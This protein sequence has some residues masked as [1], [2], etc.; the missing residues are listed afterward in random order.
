MKFH[1]IQITEGSNVGNLTVASGTAF[2]SNANE[3]E[4]FYRS[5][6][7]TTVKGLYLY[8][9]GNWDRIASADSITAPSGVTFP[10]SAN[11]GDMFYKDSDDAGEGLYVYNGATW[12][13]AA[14][15]SGSTATATGDV[16]GVLTIGGSGALTLAN[17]GVT[18]GSF[19]GVTETLTLTVDSK[20]RVT[21]VNDVQIALPAAQV[22]SGTFD[23]ARVA[24]SNV[25]QHQAALALDGSQ[26]TSG[27]IPDARVA[28]SNVTQHQAALSILESQI[29]DGAIFPRINGSETITG[30]YQFNNPVVVPTP[31]SGSHATSKDYVDQAIAGL[32]WKNSVRV[33]TTANI[34]LSG[35]Q[36]IDGVLLSAGNRVLVKDQSTSSQNGVYVVAAGAW[37]RSTDFDSI[38]PIDE[39]NSAAVFVQQGTVNADTAWTQISPVSLVGTDAITF[40]QFAGANTYLAGAGMTLSTNTF[41][42]GTASASRIVVN[43]DNIDLATVGTPV[44]DVLRRVTTDAYGRVTGT[45]A[46][47]AADLTGVLDSTYVNV[48]GDTMT[49][50]LTISSGAAMP[51]TIESSTEFYMNLNSTNVKGG[52]QR[53]QT[54]GTTYL[55]IGTTLNTIGGAGNNNTPGINARDSRSL[56]LSTNQIE[57]MRIA[58]AGQVLIGTTTSRGN[59]FGAASGLDS[60]LQIEGTTFVT[61][62]ATYTRNSA[63]TNPSYLVLAKTR[64]GA[65]GGNT[66]VAAADALGIV[67]FQGADGTNVV[68]AA[69]IRGSADLTPSAGVVPG[70]L[71]FWTANASGTITERMRI[72]SNGNVAVNT[73]PNSWAKLS[74]AG[75]VS[76]N[77]AIGAVTQVGSGVFSYEAPVFREYIGD[78]TGYSRTFSKRTASTTTDLITILD[79]SGNFG[80][81]VTSPLSRLDVRNVDAFSTVVTDASLQNNTSTVARFS[82]TTDPVAAITG[83]TGVA[84]ALS[85][86]PNRGESFLVSTHPTASKDASEFAIWT[87]NGGVAAERLKVGVSSIS[88]GN[89][90]N[91][92]ISEGTESLMNIFRQASSGATVLANGMKYTGAANGFASSYSPTWAR[93]AI[94]LGTSNGAGSIGFYTDPTSVVAAGTDVS[95]T[96]RMLI[97]NSGNVGIGTVP[98]AWTNTARAIEFSY[99]TFGMD[100]PGQAFMAFN[101]RE[102]SSGNWVYKSTDTGQ[103]FRS[104]AGGWIWSTAASGTIGGAATVTERMRLDASGNLCVGRTS[105]SGLG[106]IQTDGNVDF[107]KTTGNQIVNVRASST[108][109]AEVSIASN[110]NSQGTSDFLL[111][112]SSTNEAYIWNRSSG[113]MY[114]GTANTERMRLSASGADLGLGGTP[115]SNGAGWGTLTVNGSSG[116]AVEFNQAGTRYGQ[117]L[118]N[119]AEVR[120]AATGSNPINFFTGG[121]NSRMVITTGG[122]IGMGGNSTGVA[123]GLSH[124]AVIQYAGGGSVYGLALRSMANTTTAVSFVNAADATVGNITTGASTTAYNTTSDVRLKKN[125]QAAGSFGSVIDAIEIVSFDWKID[126]EHQRAGFIAQDLQV[127]APE[128]VK[129]GDSN[130]EITEPWAVDP[131]KLIPMLI[132]EIQELRARVSALENT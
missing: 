85:P 32:A 74:V 30:S 91:F 99:P 62:S 53:F 12:I 87:S 81:G 122:F 44:T 128:A 38:S 75:G 61:S 9:G 84:I 68:N 16:T 98:G 60:A 130:A 31:S 108:F 1:G 36:T 105:S 29:V 47:Q 72:D 28:Q 10:G 42:I 76:I 83:G 96:L 103:L 40:T 63:D 106:V 69:E 24:Q 89:T 86:T 92:S 102:T 51:L 13:P 90:A 124:Q 11:I 21:T 131:S 118:G 70:R 46:V 39:I 22:T 110:G 18:A 111:R 67:T 117:V 52:F 25:T 123:G 104:G 54:S 129:V 95:P 34:T 5:D 26:L 6:A 7:A 8:V 58:A 59:T 33:A 43:T 66:A 78:G 80:I 94:V 57:R 17:T 97:T 45:S 107:A 71:G 126:D 2:P 4:L 77:G 27:S 82:F 55:D 50:A 112:Q 119:S 3:G 37:S 48:G 19:G 64:S 65:V 101:L 15:G 113:V 132:K 109:Q 73:T 49:G 93:S 41:N 125:I 88:I 35:T 79:S 114:F 23:D 127:V 56:V 115:N 121:V 20:G 14:S 100:G 120:I 116:G